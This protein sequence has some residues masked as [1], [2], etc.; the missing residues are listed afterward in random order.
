MAARGY[1]DEDQPRRIE[2][3]AA[4]RNTTVQAL[5]IEAANAAN[6]SMIVSGF[7]GGRIRD[8]PEPW[9]GARTQ[10]R[11]AWKCCQVNFWKSSCCC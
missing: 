5:M 8:N 9:C 4:D 1:L 7:V 6:G 11:P 3:V 10:A 2:G